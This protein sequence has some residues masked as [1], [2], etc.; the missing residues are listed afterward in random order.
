ML[1][2]S[3]R[4][5]PLPKRERE[6]VLD[7]QMLDAIALLGAL[8]V[9]KAIK[10]TDEIARDAAD[11]LKFHSRADNAVLAVEPA[12]KVTHDAVLCRG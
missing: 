3:N 8:G 10:G 11:A 6:S 1:R 9:V 5:P 4:G 7:V 12:D 2:V